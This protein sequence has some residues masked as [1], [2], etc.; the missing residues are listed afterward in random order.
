MIT[1]PYTLYCKAL[2]YSALPYRDCFPFPFPSFSLPIF[3]F[4]FDMIEIIMSQNQARLRESA[5][6]CDALLCRVVQG[7][8]YLT[9]PCNHSNISAGM[10]TALA[11]TFTALIFFCSFKTVFQFLEG[12]RIVLLFPVYINLPTC[13]SLG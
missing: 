6:L 1:L 10:G 5:L 7:M 11:C 2:P 13:A 4:P 12:F 3:P 8:P 9:I